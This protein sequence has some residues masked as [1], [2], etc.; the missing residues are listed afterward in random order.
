M[1]RKRTKIEREND[2]SRIGS[3]LI[4]GLSQREIAAQVGLSQPQVGR[5]VR[6]IQERWAKGNVADLR[7][8]L[9]QEIMKLDEIER[10]CWKA[11]HDSCRDKETSCQEKVTSAKPEGAEDAM[12]TERLKASLRTERRNGDPQYLKAILASIALRDKLLGLHDRR[13]LQEEPRKPI[14]FIRVLVRDLPKTQEDKPKVEGTVSPP[15]GT[16]DIASPPAAEDDKRK[17]LKITVKPAGRQ[18]GGDG[19]K[20]SGP[21][22]PDNP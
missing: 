14:Q 9:N 3:L 12:A 1:P 5:E 16:N 13:E 18:G 21:S 10:I 11:W 8:T 19:N 15:N 22:L 17:P 7:R 20:Q 2:L 4:R 6:K